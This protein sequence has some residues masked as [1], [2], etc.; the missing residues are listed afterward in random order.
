MNIETVTFRRLYNL[1][2]YENESIEA[3]AIVDEHGPEHALETLR[4]WCDGQHKLELERLGKAEDQ[5]RAIA[6]HEY[7][8]SSLKTDI[9]AMERA[10]LKAKN[11]LVALHI[12]LPSLYVL[13]KIDDDDIPF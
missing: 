1:G 8:L 3:S 11:F 10:W 12:D 5:R 4:V 2:N 9:A 6:E 13:A 7:T